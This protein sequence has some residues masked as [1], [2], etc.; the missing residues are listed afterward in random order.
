M[1]KGYE[2]YLKDIFK[3]MAKRKEYKEEGKKNEKKKN[4][5]R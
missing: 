5:K 1:V 2:K 4:V 3:I